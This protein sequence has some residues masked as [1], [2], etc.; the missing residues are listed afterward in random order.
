LLFLDVSGSIFVDF[1]IIDFPG[2]LDENCF[3]FFDKFIEEDNGA[4]IFVIKIQDTYRDAIA[5][6]TNLLSR[7]K[8]TQNIT[9]S[10]FA[11]KADGL[12]SDHKD[13]MIIIFNLVF[14]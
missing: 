11:H 10:F 4:V 7:A 1:E 6:V 13:C 14:I 5:N 2:R 3:S 12:S 8:S 9:F